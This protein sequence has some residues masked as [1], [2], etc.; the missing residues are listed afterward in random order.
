MLSIPYLLAG[1]AVY[2]FYANEKSIEK[3]EV[4]LDKRYAP[5]LNPHPKYFFTIKGHIDKEL[6]K[7]M[8]LHFYAVYETNN[9]K[10]LRII[11]NFEG[12]HGPRD[13]RI[14]FHP[15]STESNFVVHI[16][17]DKFLL[18]KCLWKLSSIEESTIKD[19]TTADNVVSSIAEFGHPTAQNNNTVAETTYSCSNNQDCRLIHHIL[20]TKFDGQNISNHKNY[21]FIDMYQWRKQ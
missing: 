20:L 6:M 16:P 17:I 12:V 7:T 15:I 19:K 10:C 2:F 21:T 11:N 1:A 14:A 18:G 3:H 4:I 9:N 13:I 5:I 8:A